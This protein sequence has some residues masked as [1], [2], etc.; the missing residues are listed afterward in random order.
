MNFDTFDKLLTMYV[1]QKANLEKYKAEVG[2]TD[3]EIKA[4]KDGADNLQYLKDFAE[5]VEAS[6][7]AV[8]QIKQQVF[9]GDKNASIANFGGLSQ[10]ATGD[11]E[12]I[13][14]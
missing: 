12:A 4:I 1:K 2:A 9:I 8:T 3:D 11:F 6:K 7:K 10:T 14:K 13:R 5:L